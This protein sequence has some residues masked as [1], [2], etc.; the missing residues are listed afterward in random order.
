MLDKS[1]EGIEASIADLKKTPG[2]RL[3]AFNQWLI[4]QKIIESSDGTVVRL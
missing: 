2:D 4:G 3:D 1:V